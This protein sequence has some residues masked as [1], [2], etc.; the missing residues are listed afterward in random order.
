MTPGGTSL[1][2]DCLLLTLPVYATEVG[3]GARHTFSQ[4]SWEQVPRCAL[5][6]VSEHRDFAAAVGTELV[7]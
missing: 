4:P 2:E 1:R 3:S 5:R 7:L 6:E